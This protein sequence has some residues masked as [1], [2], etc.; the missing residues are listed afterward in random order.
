[1]IRLPVVL[2][3]ALGLAA[4]LAAASPVP[5]AQERHIN[6][7]LLA[8]QVGDILRKTCPAANARMFV[9]LNR[10]NALESYAR[11]KGYTEAEVKAFLK[12]RAQKARVRAEAEA[13][14]AGR[15]AVK[16]D[17]GTYCRVARDEVRKRSAVGSLLR[18]S[19]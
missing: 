18:V 17:P 4:P 7:E 6:S 5:L 11:S 9:V 19:E 14:L 12:D 2:A 1:M 15:G 13:W 3:L 8:A 10:L 16:G